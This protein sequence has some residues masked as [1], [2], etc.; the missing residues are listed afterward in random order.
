MSYGLTSF[1]RDIP[2]YALIYFVIIYIKL[3][4][5][6]NCVLKTKKSVQI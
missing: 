5:D 2:I 6:Y 1:T 3:E 4:V